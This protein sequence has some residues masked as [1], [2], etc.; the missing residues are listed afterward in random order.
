MARYMYDGSTC[1]KQQTFHRSFDLL[2][3]AQAFADKTHA[4]DIYKSKG[5]WVVEY[6]KE[7]VYDA[8][9]VLTV[10]ETVNERTGRTKT[11]HIIELKER[12]EERKC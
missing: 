11:R 5:R 8:D 6:V 12:K 4:A 9:E 7:T 2:K 3:Q 10:I 1:T